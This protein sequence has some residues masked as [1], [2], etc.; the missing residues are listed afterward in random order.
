M[1]SHHT[2]DQ[3][4]KENFKA[5]SSTNKQ[6]LY[7]LIDQ[8]GL[9]DLEA[10]ALQG[11]QVCSDFTIYLDSGNPL[12]K[13]NSNPSIWT[14]GSGLSN[15]RLIPILSHLHLLKISVSTTI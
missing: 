10:S 7:I 9:G 14:A 11:K 12:R 1:N 13:G 3:D 15:N 2:E 5:S 4:R 8:P 6:L